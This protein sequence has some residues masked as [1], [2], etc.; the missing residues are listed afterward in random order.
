[1][2]QGVGGHAALQPG[3]FHSVS[4]RLFHPSYRLAPPL[5]RVAFADPET[6]PTSKMGKEAVGQASG[7]LP[8]FRLPFA[9]RSAVKDTGSKVD[10]SRAFGLAQCSLTDRSSP[11]SRVEAHEDET[12]DV[13][14]GT[15]SG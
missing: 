8:F 1:M 9:L 3:V 7:C 5:D 12:G 15:A 13:L 14:A 11:S 10:P 2:S 4:E 6:L